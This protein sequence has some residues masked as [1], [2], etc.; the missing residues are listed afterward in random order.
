MNGSLGSQFPC[1]SSLHWEFHISFPSRVSVSAF[2]SR[3]SS[4]QVAMCRHSSLDTY[5][6]GTILLIGPLLR[7]K[8]F[9][10]NSSS[11]CTQW[12]FGVAS[13]FGIW[14]VACHKH[15]ISASY[16]YFSIAEHY[17]I[18]YDATTTTKT[19]LGG[20]LIL[21]PRI[22]DNFLGLPCLGGCGA[23]AGCGTLLRTAPSARGRRR[24]DRPMI[25]S[26]ERKPARD[27]TEVR[28]K[29]GNTPPKK[30]MAQFPLEVLSM[31]LMLLSLSLFFKFKC[32][33][34]SS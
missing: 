19:M 8:A 30:Y 1:I 21:S 15:V 26:R 20:H 17:R 10:I 34:K 32:D 2:P 9:Q 29:V 3:I 23:K 18:H 12:S 22:F 27:A 31:E 7:I 5:P 13:C 6:W 11:P 33:H 4:K 25:L 24:S 14:F 16:I 28:S